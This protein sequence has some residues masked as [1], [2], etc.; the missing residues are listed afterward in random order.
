MTADGMPLIGP[1]PGRPEILVAAGHNMHGLSLGPIT[2]ETVADL[3]S[4][5][6]TQIAG[7]RVDLG[8]F[9]VR[10]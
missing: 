9:A 5:R 4:G 10:R 6:T 7:K 2:G 3:I 8:P 1:V